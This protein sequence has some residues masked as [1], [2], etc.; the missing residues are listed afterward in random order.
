MY[1]K[2]PL[3]GNDENG[4]IPI[5]STNFANS[6][7]DL[8]KIQESVLSFLSGQSKLASEKILV[9]KCSAFWTVEEDRLLKKLLLDYG[10][11][12]KKIAKIIKTKT[13]SLVKMRVF[14]MRGSLRM[15][16]NAENRGSENSLSDSEVRERKIRNLYG[17]IDNLQRFI[18]R[19]VHVLRNAA[20]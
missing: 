19:T 11:N 8:A 14:E 16:K 7:E 15:R 2:S 18:E 5:Y 17:R 12:W 4:Y 3:K 1:S 13:P 10:K 6:A 9:K 20:V